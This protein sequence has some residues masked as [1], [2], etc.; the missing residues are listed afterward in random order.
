MR[1][2]LDNGE[3]VLIRCRRFRRDRIVYRY[4]LSQLALAEHKQVPVAPPHWGPIVRM[5]QFLRNTHVYG[6]FDGMAATNLQNLNPQ[7]GETIPVLTLG[8]NVPRSAYE[9]QVFVATSRWGNK[10]PL[11]DCAAY[12]QSLILKR[13]RSRRYGYGV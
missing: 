1:I 11:A 7:T 8:F 10:L 9:L 13:K 5:L 6:F 12:L 2:A 3:L 4:P